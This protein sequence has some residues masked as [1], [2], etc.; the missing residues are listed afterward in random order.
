MSALTFEHIPKDYYLLDFTDEE[1][2]EIL[3]KPDEWS[4]EDYHVAQIV[5]SK[6]G[7]SIPGS[8]LGKMK[9]KRLEELK[10]PDRMNFNIAWWINL[11]LGSATAGLFSAYMSWTI[12]TLKKT[13]PNGDKVYSYDLKTRKSAERMFWISLFFTLVWVVV[14]AL[15]ITG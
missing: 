15:V 14:I 9:V 3:I 13:L 1:L 7:K 12:L 5:L 6:R 8:A 4:R 11:L 10:Q 2:L